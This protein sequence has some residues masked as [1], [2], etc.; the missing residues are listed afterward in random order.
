MAVSIAL[1][2][3]K[4]TALAPFMFSITIENGKADD[5]FTEKLLDCFATGTVPIYWGTKSICKHFNMDG[6]IQFDTLE[7]LD[8]ILPTL[9]V[10]HYLEMRQAVVD[11]FH[12]AA[13]F[14]I[15]EDWICANYP[16]L[17]V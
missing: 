6:V 11:N 12:R 15:P 7:E 2:S 14:F 3:F 1:S 4:T 17:F 16:Q 9:T 13:K 10:G 8:S 5:Y